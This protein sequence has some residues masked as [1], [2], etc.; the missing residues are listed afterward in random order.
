MGVDVDVDVEAQVRWMT[1]FGVR[2]LSIALRL[3][4][5]TAPSNR[6]ALRFT[7]ERDQHTCGHCGVIHIGQCIG[8]DM[9]GLRVTVVV[10]S[11]VPVLVAVGA[12]MLVSGMTLSGGLWPW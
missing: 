11:V 10:V 4:P 3:A 12:A 7:D 1:C 2:V 8:I 9:C 5:R 6:P